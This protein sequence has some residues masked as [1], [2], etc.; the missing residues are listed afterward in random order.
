M[1]PLPLRCTIQLPAATTRSMPPSRCACSIS[2][3]T[4][5][6]AICPRRRPA[7]LCLCRPSSLCR[8]RAPC[9]RCVT[10]KC[11]APRVADA[12]RDHGRAESAPLA[13]DARGGSRVAARHG[14]R[15]RRRRRRA[16]PRVLLR[17]AVNDA[18][19]D[20]VKHSNDSL[21]V[22]F[23]ATQ[24]RLHDLGVAGEG[25]VPPSP[26]D[27]IV[28][29]PA[30]PSAVTLHFFR[31]NAGAH[32][33]HLRL[34]D[35]AIRITPR[36]V[37]ALQARFSALVHARR[38]HDS[39]RQGVSLWPRAAHSRRV[40]CASRQSDAQRVAVHVCRRRRVCV[41]VLCARHQGG[42][43]ADQGEQCRRDARR[44]RRRGRWRLCGGQRRQRASACDSS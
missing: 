11:R 24:L 42:R 16:E 30:S 31:G 5:W 4:L 38:R 1:S 33:L 44:Q 17:V 26:F 36:T 41:H 32:E 39:A 37:A 7:C 21:G 13:A 35:I 12:G 43:G 10:S 23:K 14:H 19:I 40:H 9:R 29:L 3:S 8:C 6:T 27:C 22:N 2:C 18:A 34:N 20:V 15:C 28:D 25:R